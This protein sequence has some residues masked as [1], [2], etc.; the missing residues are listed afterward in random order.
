MAK[1]L[2]ELSGLGGATI[3]KTVVERVPGT[4]K[5]RTRAIY[6][7]GTSE[8]LTEIPEGMDADVA[9]ILDDS[10]DEWWKLLSRGAQQIKDALQLKNMSKGGQLVMSKIVQGEDPATFLNDAISVLPELEAH[11][12]EAVKKVTGHGNYYDF[13]RSRLKRFDLTEEALDGLMRKAFPDEYVDGKQL[14]ELQDE[15]Y[16]RFN[17][18]TMEGAEGEPGESIL[19]L[20][21]LE[22]AI[23]TEFGDNRDPRNLIAAKGAVRLLR[24]ERGLYAE[25]PRYA[26]F[27]DAFNLTE[28][29]PV[30]GFKTPGKRDPM[31]PIEPEDNP[32]NEALAR[33]F[34]NYDGRPRIE[35][36]QMVTAVM[37]GDPYVEGWPGVT[38]ILRA[39]E[40]QLIINLIREQNMD[41]YNDEHVN[42]MYRRLIEIGRIEEKDAV[43]QETGEQL[44]ELMSANSKFEEMMAGGAA[45]EVGYTRMK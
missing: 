11:A 4:G 40:A 37:E 5:S 15:W 39:S 6:N 26:G 27:G 34:G 16:N 10:M 35:N 33:D 25:D 23:E 8:I 31:T 43:M 41:V 22:A 44:G 1:T 9:K 21:S 13:V 36:H 17:E 30:T 18:M 3:H 38:G 29:D 20:E 24:M 7:D 45:P 32:Y 2:S 42:L 19:D 12:M 28:T 14:M